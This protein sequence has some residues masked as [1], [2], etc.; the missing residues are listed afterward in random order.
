M[1]MKSGV[2]CPV[3]ATMVLIGVSS[4][5]GLS[6]QAQSSQDLVR[7]LESP[8]S[9][10]AASR[11]LFKI[12]GSDHDLRLQLGTA[13]PTIIEPGPTP[14]SRQV[15]LNAVRLAGGLKIA[16][17]APALTKWIGLSKTNVAYSMGQDEN[18]Y[19]SETGRAL[20]EI[21][22]PAVPALREGLENSNPG[23]RTRASYALF[24][25]NSPDAKN[26]LR[27]HL[28]HEPDSSLAGYIKKRLAENN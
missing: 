10:T 1:T 21:G 9:T 14:N 27:E 16:E 19:F 15:W 18:L 6:T 5:W 28:A 20:V 12:A 13:L 25:I 17:A 22:E 8:A 26:A 4:V 23:V 24:L 2:R 7:Q 3:A 11:K